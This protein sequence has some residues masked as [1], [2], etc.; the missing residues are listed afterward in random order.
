MCL[1]LCVC[2]C[3][4]VVFVCVCMC[5][6]MCSSYTHIH[7]LT[8]THT[9]SHIHSYIHTHTHTHI[10]TNTQP[11]FRGP[12]LMSYL[13]YIDLLYAGKDKVSSGLPIFSSIIQ[14]SYEDVAP[15]YIRGNYFKTMMNCGC[16]HSFLFQNF[17]I[18]ICAD[19][20]G[21]IYHEMAR[22]F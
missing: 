1:Y 21:I 6:Y 18:N 13:F 4:C 14:V 19:I 8:H 17:Y 7:T 9:Y 22:I 20:E 5:V 2:V 12:T 11:H 3:V 16:W 15:Q 10:H